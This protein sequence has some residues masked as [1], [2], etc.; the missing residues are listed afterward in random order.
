[1]R[2]HHAIDAMHHGQY[3]TCIARTGVLQAPLAYAQY[4]DTMSK[5]VRP[6]RRQGE[7]VFHTSG[8]HGAHVRATGHTLPQAAQRPTAQR[9]ARGSN[10]QGV[11]TEARRRGP[12]AVRGVPRTVPRAR[13]RRARARRNAT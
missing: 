9:P 7:V 4:T 10:A 6:I 3:H 13:W 5:A 8:A 2:D 12:H 11:N 1:M